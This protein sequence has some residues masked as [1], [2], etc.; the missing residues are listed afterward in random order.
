MYNVYIGLRRFDLICWVVYV[1]KQ[2]WHQVTC[3]NVF[4]C[5][6]ALHARERV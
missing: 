5:L 6:V 4:I 2:R 1:L 3:G